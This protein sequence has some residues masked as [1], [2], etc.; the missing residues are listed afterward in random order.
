MPEH[1]RRFTD[2]DNVHIPCQIKT[3]SSAP[4]A[5]TGTKTDTTY[6]AVGKLAFE[7]LPILLSR[8]E[9]LEGAE[10]HDLALCLRS[11]PPFYLIGDDLLGLEKAKAAQAIKGTLFFNHHQSSSKPLILK[12][13]AQLL[14]NTILMHQKSSP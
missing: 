11:H 3:D 13:G 14:V 4:W 6:Y 12:W 2:I 7:L 1:I 10:A 8:L 5:T 9:S